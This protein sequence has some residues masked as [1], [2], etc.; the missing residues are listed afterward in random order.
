MPV[1]D[2]QLGVHLQVIGARAPGESPV[3]R[4][5]LTLDD[6]SA[7]MGGAVMADKLRG[8]VAVTPETIVIDSLTGLFADGP[9]ALSGT[10]ER[11]TGQLSLHA[12]ARPDLDVL[13]RL[14]VVPGGTTLSGNAALDLWVRGALDALDD[15]EVSGT[16]GL[17]GLQAKHARLAVPLY[18]PVGEITLTSHAVARSELPVL[19]GRDQ[20]ITSGSV[21]DIG[22][23]GGGMEASLPR[24]D[25]SLRG[26]RLNLDA[27]F[28]AREVASETTYSRIVL[29]QETE[30]GLETLSTTTFRPPTGFAHVAPMEVMS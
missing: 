17:A 15:V 6:V 9:M 23:L 29:P 1:L 3:V 18:V 21:T 11:G 24:V 4:G 10:I 14:G 7:R 28:P 26:E 22:F 5:S 8:I 25:I 19:V 20:M 16:I 30:I 12:K 13:D 27:A 2:G